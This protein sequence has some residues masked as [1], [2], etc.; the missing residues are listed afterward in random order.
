V[1]EIRDAFRRKA[2]RT[3]PDKGGDT[4]LF[5]LIQEA[6]A[7]LSDPGRRAAYDAT[8]DEMQDT[9]SHRND[10]VKNTESD[11]GDPTPRDQ[12]SEQRAAPGRRPLGWWPVIGLIALGLACWVAGDG[13][14]KDDPVFVL[15]G[16]VFIGLAVAGRKIGISRNSDTDAPERRLAMTFRRFVIGATK[17][18][19][20]IA[21]A[22]GL[23]VGG[24][25]LISE[26]Q[27]RSRQLADAPLA[28]R[29]EW[30]P[31]TAAALGGSVFNLATM[32]KD[33]KLYYQLN[34]VGY[35]ANI[36]AA[37]DAASNASFTL[38]FNNAQGF[39]IFSKQIQLN[40]MIAIVGGD[41]QRTGLSWAGDEF[42]TADTYREAASWEL[43]WAGISDLPRKPAAAPAPVPTP[44]A[45]QPQRADWQQRANW[46]QL[47][48]GTPA[49]QV[50]ELLGEPTR[51]STF[52]SAGT[53]WHY[54]DYG[55]VTLAGD[56]TVRSWSEP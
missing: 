29:K 15:L 1:S 7:V 21:L 22:I 9:T 14:A 19:A 18:G 56:N 51:V 53:I 45:P 43:S 34:V 36:A 23:L 42:Q 2:H 5:I 55:M 26:Q 49:T 16:W 31:M 37:R 35:P 28:M 10:D 52:G 40:E 41:A 47:L 48:I 44:R 50:R 27:N 54:G 17:I 33:S 30:P 39:R 24:T 46:R 6:Y 3:H 12:P 20:G 11:D 38:L 25:W 13:A 8:L 32:W 4:D